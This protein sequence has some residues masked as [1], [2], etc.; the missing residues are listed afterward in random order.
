MAHYHK[1]T[2]R[3]KNGLLGLPCSVITAYF[4]SA[5]QACNHWRLYKK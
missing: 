1:Y 2:L 5:I 3:T 4:V